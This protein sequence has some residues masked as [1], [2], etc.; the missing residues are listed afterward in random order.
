M[1]PKYISDLPSHAVKHSTEVK[2]LRMQKKEYWGEF[3]P[4]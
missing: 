3:V 1:L 4:E 2:I